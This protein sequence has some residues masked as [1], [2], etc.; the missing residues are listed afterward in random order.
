MRQS[1]VLFALT[2]WFGVPLPTGLG[3][4]HRPILDV[5]TVKPAPAMIP[6]G[7]EGHAELAGGAVR[8]H[9]EAIVGISRGDRARGEKA[10][11]RITGFRAADETHAWVLQQFKAAGL[12]DPQT[13]TYTSTQATWYPESWTVKLLANAKAGPDSRDVV[14]ESAFPTSG[15]QLQSPITAPLIFVGA[16]TDGALP[17]AD[18]KGKVAVQTLHPQA[19]AYSERTRTTERAREL[20]KRGAVAVLNIVEQAGNMYLRDFSNCGV[21]CFNVGTDDGR[22]LKAVMEHANAAGAAA[23]LRVAIALETDMRQGLQGHNT[24]GIVP[25]R[26]DDEIVIV[27]AHADGWFDAAGDN[28]D[29]LA[30]LVAL[31]RHFAKAPQPERTLLFVASGGHHGAGMNG[32]GNLVTMNPALVKRAVLVLNLEHIAQLY[33]RNDPFRVEASEQPMGFG[34]SNEAPGIAEIAKRGMRRYG[35]A[36]RPQ[37]SSSIAGDLGGYAPLGV[38]RVQ[39][40]HSGPMYHTSGD[41]LDTIS[42]PGLER[43]ARFYAFFIGEVASADRTSLQPK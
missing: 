11:G 35:F 29:G 3:D 24:I 30:V 33:F 41:T 34:I 42:T 1:I 28:G 18:V 12:R 5:A 32:P 16:T 13:Q 36:L 23:D 27:N 37:F 15:S 2:L 26:R 7:E 21:P 19:G 43:A 40:I 6:P 14:L 39:A 8:K 38:P 17:E 31:A 9:L 20:A 10:W 4:P 22:F 25:G